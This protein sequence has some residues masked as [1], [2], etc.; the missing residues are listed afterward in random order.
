[1]RN[2][3]YVGGECDFRFCDMNDQVHDEIEK[4]EC[5]LL[6]IIRDQL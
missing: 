1:M 2:E 5:R 4:R 3:R 6:W